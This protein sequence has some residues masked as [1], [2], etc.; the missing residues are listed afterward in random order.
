MYHLGFYDSQMDM[1]G[2]Q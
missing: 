1:L 2:L